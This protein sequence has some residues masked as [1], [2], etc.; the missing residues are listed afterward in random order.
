MEGFLSG[1]TLPG[2]G[3]INKPIIYFAVMIFFCALLLKCRNKPEVGKNELTETVTTTSVHLKPPSS[4][5][6]TFIVKEPAAVFYNPDSM[7][8][9]K[10]RSVNHKMIF[11][12]MTHDCYYQKRNAMGVINKFWPDVGI[13]EI[14]NAR[15]LLFIK[16]DQSRTCIDLNTKNDMCGMFLFEPENNPVLADMMNIDKELGRYFGR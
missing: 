7:Q 11:E 6:D 3:I 5:S 2:C 1:L 9:E 16:S 15:Y 14:S 12:S 8:L 13:I 4:F 10:I